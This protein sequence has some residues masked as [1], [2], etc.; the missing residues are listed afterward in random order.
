MCL[1]AAIAGILLTTRL[2]SATPIAGDE[3]NLIVIG[4]AIV[5]G[6]STCGGIGSVQKSV[7]GLLIFGVILNT[8]D[9]L[10]ISGYFQQVV[11][12]GVNVNAKNGRYSKGCCR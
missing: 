6:T 3:L 2:W 12:G 4:A 10:K 7:I 1:A 11:R 5:G 9:V 8:M